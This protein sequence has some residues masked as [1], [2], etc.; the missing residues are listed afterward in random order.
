M[1]EL[2]KITKIYETEK[3][4]IGYLWTTLGHYANKNKIKFLI[5]DKKVIVLE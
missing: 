3:Y 2:K 4:D 1:L 5:D